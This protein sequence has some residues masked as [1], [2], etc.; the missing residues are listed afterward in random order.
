MS[1]R[2]EMALRFM[3]MS[4]IQ[5]LRLHHISPSPLATNA[6]LCIPNQAP[7]NGDVV[8]STFVDVKMPK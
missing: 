3:N 7:N 6:S 5:T 1:F 2:D 4:A 8:K